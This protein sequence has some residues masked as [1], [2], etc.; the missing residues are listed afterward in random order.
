[1]HI[2][3]STSF[4]YLDNLF[5]LSNKVLCSSSDKYSNQ[6][7]QK[8]VNFIAIKHETKEDENQSNNA[9]FLQKK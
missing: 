8:N 1:M 6:H 4:F 2:D 5:F 7:N 3:A 9:S